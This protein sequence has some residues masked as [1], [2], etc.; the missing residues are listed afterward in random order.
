[1]KFK[2]FSEFSLSVFTVTKL[3]VHCLQLRVGMELIVPFTDPKEFVKGR[4]P[5]TAS[6]G[7]ISFGPWIPGQ[8]D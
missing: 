4:D 3:R 5:L 2:N 7:P 6:P 1:M 8:R